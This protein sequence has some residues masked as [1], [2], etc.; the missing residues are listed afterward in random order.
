MINLAVW[1]IRGANTQIKQ[2]E[3]RNLLYENRI[4]VM[5]LLETRVKEENVERVLRGICDWNVI[6][7]YHDAYNGRVWVMWDPSR[8]I[9]QELE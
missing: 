2:I 9:V 8:V 4:G 3:V 7:N 1:N 6:T 5:G